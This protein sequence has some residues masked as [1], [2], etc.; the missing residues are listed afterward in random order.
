MDQLHF[1]D[2]ENQLGS[3]MGGQLDDLGFGL[4]EDMEALDLGGRHLGNQ[5]IQHELYEDDE[6]EYE[7]DGF[8]TTT[9]VQWTHGVYVFA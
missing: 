7:L 9:N 8:W 4:S 6:E 1:G 2:D 5:G 3:M